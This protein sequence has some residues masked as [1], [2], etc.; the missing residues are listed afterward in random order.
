MTREE[1][2]A[3]PAN[4]NPAATRKSNRGVS[5]L[6]VAVGM[7]FILGMAGL[8]VDLASLYVARSQAQRAADAAALAGAQA[9]VE[10]GCASGIAGNISGNCQNLAM[11]RAQT[12][13]DS[14]LIAGVTPNIQTTDITFPSTSTTDPQIQVAAGRGTY[15]GFDH[16]NPLST[17]F[18]KIFG[19]TSANVSAVAT[20]EAYNASGGTAPVG[21]TCVK[22]WLLPNCD[23]NNTSPANSACSSPAASFVTG[24]GIANASAIGELL[25]I[26]PGDPSEAIGPGKFYPVYLPPG[27]VAN[28]CPDCAKNQA[29][30]GTQSGDQ[31]RQNIE[32][33]NQNPIVCGSN[34]VLAISGNMVGPTQ[35]GVKCLIHQGNGNSG[36]QDTFDPSTFQILSGG[37]YA[38]VGTSI[39]T[40]DSIATIPIYD[41]SP[42]C[43]GGSNGN[44]TCTQQA[45]VTVIGFMR[46]FIKDVGTGQSPVHAYVMSIIDCHA[47]AGGGGGGTG[48]SGGGPIIGAGGTAIPVRLI[49]Q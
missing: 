39:T 20:A 34:K 33:C 24:S 19:I 16:G 17:F 8:A 38:P 22:P 1:K 15:N 5:V 9:F 7:V 30:S 36:G 13:G 32:C 29:S 23:P 26:K 45:D 49:R 43:P 42:I 41:G 4:S 27:Q 31:Y 25:T 6:I 12:I 18:V 47:G 46:V 14:N 44:G 2:A 35:Q 37:Y 11:Q 21:S 48:G 3:M 40:S 10:A 28:A